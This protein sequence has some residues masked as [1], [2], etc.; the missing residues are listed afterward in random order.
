VVLHGIA[1]EGGERKARS[2]WALG[3]FEKRQRHDG[4]RK[5]VVLF[6]VDATMPGIADMVG[7]VSR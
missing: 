1:R 2:V 6:F 3:I 7:A 5:L 4:N